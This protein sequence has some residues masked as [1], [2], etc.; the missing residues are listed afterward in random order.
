MNKELLIKLQADKSL[1]FLKEAD[2]MVQQERWD[3]AANRFY[4][5]CYHMVHAIFIDRGITTKTHNGTLSEFGKNIVL[6]GLIDKR[7]GHFYARMLQLRFKADYNS[8][9]EVTKTEVLEL[10]PLSHQFIDTMRSLLSF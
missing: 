1:R 5:A 10:A 8:V 3:L 2:D 7:F 9:A 4:Y 6:P